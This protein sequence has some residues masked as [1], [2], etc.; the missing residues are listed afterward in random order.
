MNVRERTRGDSAWP[1]SGRPATCCRERYLMLSVVWMG[2]PAGFRRRDLPGPSSSAEATF[3]R[4]D[5][6]LS[7]HAITYTTRG[8]IAF[9]KTAA[10]FRRRPSVPTVPRKTVHVAAHG[11]HCGLGDDATLDL[12]TAGDDPPGASDLFCVS[13]LGVSSRHSTVRHTTMPMLARPAR[14]PSGGRWGIEPNALLFNPV[15]GNQGEGH[16]E[17]RVGGG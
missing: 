11:R 13:P 14:L 9:S 5:A 16:G 12:G 17:D 1:R 8:S 3:G 6:G 10:P 15:L 7:G 2:A 4:S